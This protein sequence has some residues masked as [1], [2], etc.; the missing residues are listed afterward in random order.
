MYQK[1]TSVG[2]QKLKFNYRISQ[3]SSVGMGTS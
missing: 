3:E 1:V 2:S